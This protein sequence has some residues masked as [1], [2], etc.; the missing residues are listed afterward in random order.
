MS[1]AVRD[2]KHR[3]RNMGWRFVAIAAAFLL[4]AG[5][6]FSVMAGEG[7]RPEMG[8]RED[9]VEGEAGVAQYRGFPKKLL[10]FKW[11]AKTP[12]CWQC[13]HIMLRHRAC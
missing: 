10:S 7:E 11:S 12:C 13:Y 1:R 8:E 4:T 9:R 2:Q 6:P 5:A 3:N